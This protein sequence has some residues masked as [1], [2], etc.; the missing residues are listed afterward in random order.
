MKSINQTLLILLAFILWMR[1][2]EAHHTN[3]HS[4][5]DDTRV[6]VKRHP[7]ADII[8]HNKAIL[9]AYREYEAKVSAVWGD[10]AVVPSSKISVT[11][12]DNLNQRSIVDY[13]Q[14]KIQVQV[15]VTP[16]QSNSNEASK[17]LAKAIEQTILQPP[18]ARSI[19]DIAKNP[20]PPRSDKRPALEG[21][22]ANGKGKP[23][24]AK[25]IKSFSRQKVRS[26]MKKPIIGKDGR[27][28]IILSTE[29]ELVPDHIRRRAKKFTDAV[30]LNA[31][32]NQIPT[33]LIYAIMET[34]SYFNPT[35]K[36]PVPAFGLMQL[37]PET[38]ARDAYKYLYSKD[39][40]LKDT[41]LYNADNN[42]ELGVAYLHLLYYRYLRQIKDPTSRQW[43]T[44]AA[45]NTG[46]HNVIRSFM[47]E[48]SRAKHSSRWS[49][50]QKA[51]NKINRMKPEQV[52]Q[53]LRKYLP[54][55]ETRDYMKKVRENIPKYI[56]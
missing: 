1:P 29:F 27:K 18:D 45:Y 15:A 24:R 14:G 8:E 13:E 33:H 49:W 31:L 35:A 10:E 47:G 3:S 36:S 9:K 25:D 11:Y 22:V 54:A 30:N 20:T 55:E 32:R 2:I 46:V 53:Y 12:R 21:L 23:L 40:L 52:Y 26:L 50:K 4:Q 28:R 19:I 6:T 34:E 5:S 7:H 48:Y 37:V 56:T 39:V 38:G 42:I 16:A 43:A 44:I 51:I 41:Y 17:K